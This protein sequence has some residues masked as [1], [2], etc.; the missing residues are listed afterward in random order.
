MGKFHGGERK[1]EIGRGGEGGGLCLGLSGEGN[2]G[3]KT[4][5]ND[6]LPSGVPWGNN[7]RTTQNPG[8]KKSLP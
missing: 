2:R 1:E 8:K 6:C 5:E 3:R 7:I 4:W